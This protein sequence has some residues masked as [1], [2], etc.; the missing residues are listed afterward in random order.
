MQES[1]QRRRK[2]L[3]YHGLH[4]RVGKDVPGILSRQLNQDL[5]LG[6]FL[7]GADEVVRAQ[8]RDT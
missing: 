2:R 5:S 6:E 1:C 4:D 8:F 7:D 3:Q